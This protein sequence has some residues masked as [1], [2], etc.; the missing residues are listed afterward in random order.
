MTSLA[1]SQNQ[2]LQSLKAEVGRLKR[3]N[4][5]LRKDAAELRK[6][7]PRLAVENARL[8]ADNSRLTSDAK[9]GTGEMKQLRADKAR[10]AKRVEELERAA[11]EREYGTAVERATAEE[12]LAVAPC[13]QDVKGDAL[14]ATPASTSS[15]AQA[16]KLVDA[17]TNYSGQHNGNVIVGRR[18]SALRRAIGLG[19]PAATTTASTTTASAKLFRKPPADKV[20]IG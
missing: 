3:E 4:A 16:K 12:T 8:A 9:K 6:A 13:D 1:Q 11:R 17:V 7:N 10:L 20:A 19:P 5:A 15:G 18:A 14:T 2:T